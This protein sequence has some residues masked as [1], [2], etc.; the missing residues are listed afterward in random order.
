MRKNSILAFTLVIALFGLYFSGKAQSSTHV[1]T[2]MA[3]RKVAIP[4]T[5]TSVC[6]D[7]FA[8][9]IVFALDPKTLLNSTFSLSAEAKKYISADYYQNKPLTEDNDEETLKMK[10]SVIIFGN[11]GGSS[12]I[13]DANATQ[14]RLK[15]PVLI[16]DFQLPKYKQI[17][18]FLGKALG[19]EDKAAPIIAFLDKYVEPIAQKVKTIQGNQR[20]K[21]YYAEGAKGENTEPSGSFHSQ[22]IDFLKAKNVAKTEMGG[23][24]GMSKASMEQVLVWNPEIILVW[25]GFPGG[26]GMGN[27]GNSSSTYSHIMSDLVWAKVK[28][29]KEKKVYR[30][31]SLP[32]G[33]FDRPPTSNCLPGL[34]WAARLLYPG[35]FTFN[36]NSA[37]KEYFNLFYH[38]NIS[39]KDAEYLLNK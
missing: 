23:V 7:R 16:I 33:W 18:S 13:A 34:F 14:K 11:V 17:Y 36:I 20:P 27:D 5:I 12:T 26:V 8:S 28:A 6:T 24:H 25:T 19:R 22:V 10:P 38:V 35:Q 29:V 3:G 32:F 21:V 30:I 31:P 4:T 2:D 1:V 37:T 9:L 39:D 15:I